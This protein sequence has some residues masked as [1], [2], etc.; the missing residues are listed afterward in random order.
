MAKKHPP[1]WLTCGC[2]CLI[3]CGLAVGALIGA[4]YVGTSAVKDYVES[5]KD[6]AA[7]AAKASEILGAGQ[8]PEGYA[9][10]FYLRIPW[11][12]DM[13]V[14]TLAVLGM[15]VAWAASYVCFAGSKFSV[16]GRCQNEASLQLYGRPACDDGWLIH[17]PFRT[18][19]FWAMVYSRPG[20]LC[21][22]CYVEVAATKPSWE[23]YWGPFG[24]QRYDLGG[25]GLGTLPRIR[26]W[27]IYSPMGALMVLLAA[28]PAIA[29][30]RGPFRRWRRRRKGRCLRCGYNLEGNESGTCPECGEAVV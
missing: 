5:M 29:F 16:D 9:A 17:W 13:V 28:Y 2:G 11:V 12:L 15:G 18:N 19:S 30:I 8:L 20:K 23:K 4:G 22:A 7:R 1:L 10:Q 24:I 21:L 25:P 3:L 26:R 6:P 14:L 27:G